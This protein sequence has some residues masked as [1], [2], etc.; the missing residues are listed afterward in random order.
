MTD[1]DENDADADRCGATCRDGSSCNA[2]PVDGSDRCRMHGAEAGPP[3]GNQN[4]S[5][6]GLYSDPANLLDDL[7]ANDPEGY[8]WVLKKYDS[9][10]DSAPFA[11]GSA[12]ADQLKQVC[13]QE[14]VIWRAVAMQIHDGV[15]I[16]TNEPDG[17]AY[18]DTLKEHP[19]NLPLDRMQR[20]VS[21][22]LADLG[23][24]DDEADAEAADS[25]ADAIRELMSGIDKTDE[26]ER[27]SSEDDDE[28]ADAET[29]SESA[30][31]DDD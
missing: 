25:K 4:A 9:Y 23:V 7:A 27:S 3:T 19:V 26:E 17:T 20:T 12:K 16:E 10:L 13:A 5:R 29:E 22:R 30:E 1:N 2:Y 21:N 31:D 6:H 11:D 14:F 24:L 28:E 18:G 8:D 15:V